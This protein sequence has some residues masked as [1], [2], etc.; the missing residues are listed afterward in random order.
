VVIRKYGEFTWEKAS[1][2]CEFSV[3]GSQFSVKPAL[4]RTENW[5][6]FLVTKAWAHCPFVPPRSTSVREKL[7]FPHPVCRTVKGGLTEN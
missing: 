3:L 7:N 5:E 2:W 4:L 1:H 6:L